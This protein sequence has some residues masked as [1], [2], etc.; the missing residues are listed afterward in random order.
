MNNIDL[1]RIVTNLNNAIKAQQI[2]TASLTNILKLLNDR[3]AKV[4]ER[5]KHQ[6]VIKYFPKTRSPNLKLVNNVKENS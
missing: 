3:N 6:D 4:D 1:K 2:A 5:L